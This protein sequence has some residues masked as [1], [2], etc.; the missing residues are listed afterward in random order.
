MN[1]GD[2]G[3]Q[4]IEA[5]MRE[6]VA[7]CREQMAFDATDLKDPEIA[8][9]GKRW[10]EGYNEAMTSGVDLALEAWLAGD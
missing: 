1:I 2:E 10:I 8:K 6:F 3:Q 4:L 9:K 7:Y 5:I